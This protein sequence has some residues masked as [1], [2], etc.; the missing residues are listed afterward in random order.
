MEIFFLP[1]EKHTRVHV[2]GRIRGFDKLTNFEYNVF[3]RDIVFKIRDEMYIIRISDT[4]DI[5]ENN[6]PHEYDCTNSNE[7]LV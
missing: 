3:L 5:K 6:P 1:N 4:S 7:K 2:H